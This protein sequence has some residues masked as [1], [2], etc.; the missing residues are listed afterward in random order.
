MK[1]IDLTVSGTD[2]E[3]AGKGGEGGV[4]MITNAD[5]VAAV[6]P[7]APER[8]FVAVCSKA[9]DPGVGGWRASRAD[10]VIENLSADQ[11]NFV[12]CSSF[13]P[14][15]DGSFKAR[16]AQFAACH[17][18]MLDDLGTKVPLVR[19]AGFKLTWLIETSPGNYQGGIMLTEPIT[20]GAVAVRLLTAMIVAGLCD[21]GA[22]GPLSRWARL[23][24]AINGK[25]KHADE[26]GV[27]FRCRLVEWRPDKRYTP[28]EIVDG[29]QLELA[30]AGRPKKEAKTAADNPR[31]LGNEADDV[32]TPRA[33]ENPVVSA[34]KIR[35]LYKTPLGSGKHDVTCPWV[36]EHTDGLDSGAAYF[37]PDELYPLG[38]FCC[39]H[40]HREKFHIR[41]LLE[42]LGVPRTEARH[43]PVIRVV[44]GDLHRVV[45]AAEK[46]LANRGRH[47]QSGGLIVSVSTDPTSGDPSIVP[48]SAPALMRELSVTASWEKYDSRAKDWV[49][50]DP[51][52]L[53]VAILYD[54]Q[55]FRH[56]PPLAGVVRQPYFRE[57]D[58]ELITQAGYDKTSQ[59]YGVFDSRQFVI[60]EPTLE[61]A[62]AALALLEDLLTEFHFVSDTDKA[63]ALS[64]IFTAVVRPSLDYAPAFH[65]RAPVSGSGKTYLCELIGAFAGPGGNAKVSYPTSSE[66]ATKV[67]L[68]LL[69]TSPA[70]IEFDDMDTDWIPHGTIKRMLTAEKITDRIL[71]ISKTATVSTRTLFLGSGNNV[72]PV[73]D[74]LRRVLTIHI[75]PRC[76]TPA[77][78]TYKNFPVEKV[79]KQRVCYVAAVLTIILAWRRAG[80]PRAAV[81]SIV[82]FGGAWSEYCRYPLMW[83]GHPDPATAL[84]EQVK[85]DPDGDSIAEL[86]TEWMKAF[87]STP[88]TVRKAVELAKWQLPELFDAMRE[89]PVEDKS[90]F[91]GI[92]N[93]KLGWILKKNSN[94]IVAGLKFQ[95]ATADGRPAWRVVA[96]NPPASPALPAFNQP[97]VKTVTPN[98]VTILDALRPS[99][100]PGALIS[101][102][103]QPEATAQPGVGAQRIPS[104]SSAVCDVQGC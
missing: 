36:Q 12:G 63:A 79:R 14:G 78:M 6:F 28:Q 74:L 72:G 55:T 95:P 27:P 4:L 31:S 5:F 104:S 10:A 92:N 59:R 38:G 98:V 16:K 82:T 100:R 50:C 96:V 71:G 89:L 58:G 47:Y 25:L 29:L 65:A 64:A 56:L 40:S 13:Y 1:T 94:R 85:H 80:A 91:R 86:M 93:S 17:F 42:F 26:A 60:P 102:A 32:L 73:R 75:D 66:E 76:A 18:L 68:A 23:P 87:G 54:G 67:I 52:S 41:Q 103:A 57:S 37:E 15:E 49:R 46:E 62:Q 20:D 81:E 88:T 34:L 9:G 22:T 24:V 19:L 45:D 3:E 43:K 101:A 69:L 30:P 90:S 44:A 70:V 39:Q 83:L 99:S 51:P 11:N 21:A 53:P 7:S 77:T 61:A 84:L 35:G 48:T 8:A 97:V 2:P 33:A